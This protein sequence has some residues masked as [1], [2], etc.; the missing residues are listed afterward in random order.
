MAIAVQTKEGC[1]IFPIINNTWY[2]EDEI[3]DIADEFLAGYILYIIVDSVSYNKFY[4][5][6][7]RG[8]KI[9]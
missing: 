7:L 1:H 6:L 9:E 3:L 8:G 5:F 4:K 2:D